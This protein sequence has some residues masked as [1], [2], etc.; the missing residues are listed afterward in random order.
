MSLITKKG[1]T[2]LGYSKEGTW[3]YLILLV[4][5]VLLSAFFGYRLFEMNAVRAVVLGLLIVVQLFYI[6]RCGHVDAPMLLWSILALTIITLGSK[7]N[8]GVIV[9]YIPFFILL[10]KNNLAAHPKLTRVFLW[11]AVFCA[12]GIALQMLLPEETFYSLVLSQFESYQQFDKVER[13][14]AAKTVFYGFMYDS[15]FTAR[16]LVFGIAGLVVMLANKETKKKPLMLLG[17]IIFT[18]GLL[19]TGKRT[20]LAGMLLAFL[21]LYYCIAPLQKKIG[22]LL[23]ILIVIAIGFALLPTLANLLQIEVLT[24]IVEAIDGVMNGE[25]LFEYRSTLYSDAIELFRENPLLGIG[26]K[27]FRELHVNYW[28]YELDVHNVY[29]Q[30]LCETGICG[31]LLFAIFFVVN[32]NRAIKLCRMPLVGQEQACARFML[33]V[34]VFFL[35]CC[36]TENELY[37][38]SAFAYYFVSCA[39]VQT[40]YKR[41]KR[42]REKGSGAN[43]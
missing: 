11:I 28:G 40:R 31:F 10:W 3:L 6:M 36:V 7:F 5:P 34:Q 32:L 30:L 41:E 27:Q 38:I 4:Y 24:E 25:S 23:L 37:N 39:Y 2:A 12:A 9:Q 43:G 42:Q 21:I 17:V 1:H 19:L 16:H 18:V 33:F 20:S 22:R 14:F 35:L 8:V 29:L 26:W 15:A 13:A